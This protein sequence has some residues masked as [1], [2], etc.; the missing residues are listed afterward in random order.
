MSIFSWRR[1]D[2]EA[3]ESIK[4]IKRFMFFVWGFDSVHCFLFCFL[5]WFLCPFGI[6]YWGKHDWDIIFWFPLIYIPLSSGSAFI[7]ILFHVLRLLSFTSAMSLPGWK[8]QASL[9]SWLVLV[10]STGTSKSSFLIDW[11]LLL[12]FFGHCCSQLIFISLIFKNTWTIL[13]V[14]LK[15]DHHPSSH[16]TLASSINYYQQKA[17]VRV[18]CKPCI[19]ISANAAI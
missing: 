10:Y 19:F 18:F 6:D 8:E 13:N 9:Q 12:C 16:L 3:D 15:F 4:S 14:L 2:D 5:K 1:G 7:Y 17:V 11:S